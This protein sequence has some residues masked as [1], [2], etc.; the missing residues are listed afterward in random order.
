MNEKE[1][2]QSR[3]MSENMAEVNTKRKLELLALARTRF[4]AERGLLSWMRTTVSLYT[5]GFSMIL[6]YDYLKQQQKG[7]LVREDIYNLGIYLICAGIILLVPAI[8]QH[9]LRIRRA[10][11][12]GMPILSR[13]SLPIGGATTFF[14]LGTTVL[15]AILLR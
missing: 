7:N 8:G 12:L 10:K 13:F 15:I 6:F 2:P 9:V 3:L 1:R 5:F 11:E 4:S 14:L